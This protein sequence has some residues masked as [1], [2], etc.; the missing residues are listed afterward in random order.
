[1]LLARLAPKGNLGGCPLAWLS[2]MSSVDL[3]ERRA[4]RDVGGRL[5]EPG[6]PLAADPGGPARRAAPLADLATS[7][8]PC[9]CS[10]HLLSGGVESLDFRAPPCA[11]ISGSQS[12]GERAS[13]TTTVRRAHDRAQ[14]GGTVR[15]RSLALAPQPRCGPKNR[16]NPRAAQRTGGWACMR[17]GDRRRALQISTRRRAA[18]SPFARA[19]RTRESSPNQRIGCSPRPRSPAGRGPI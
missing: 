12:S 5:G 19:K 17:R 11:R 9:I 16:T 1:M 8:N 7:G 4:L 6:A 14:A 13:M 3:A 18:R 10:Y 2:P 15:A